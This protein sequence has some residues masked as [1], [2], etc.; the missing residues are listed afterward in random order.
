MSPFHLAFQPRVLIFVDNK[1]LASRIAAYLDSCLPPYYRNK[2]LVRHYH[3][4]M[5]E[6]YLQVS[7]NSFVD[8]DGICRIMVAT[9]AQSVV[10]FSDLV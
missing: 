5:S 1:K 8:P 7:H 2:G 3:S 6:K 9:S 4:K 10:R